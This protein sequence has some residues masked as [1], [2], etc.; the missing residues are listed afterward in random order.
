MCSAG[1]FGTG[2]PLRSDWL[3]INFQFIIDF[4]LTDGGVSNCLV[5]MEAKAFTL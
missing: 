1:R 3:I 5:K 2:A 4:P